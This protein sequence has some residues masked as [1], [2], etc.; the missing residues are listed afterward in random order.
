METYFVDMY[1]HAEDFDDLK[2]ILRPIVR[3]AR[4]DRGASLAMTVDGKPVDILHDN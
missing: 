2:E 3:K 4:G 1:V